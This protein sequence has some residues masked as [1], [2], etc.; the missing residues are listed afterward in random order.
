MNILPVRSLPA[1]G[2]LVLAVACGGA[3][4]DAPFEVRQRFEAAGLSPVG[5]R[6]SIQPEHQRAQQRYVRAA[7]ATLKNLGEWLGPFPQPSLAIVDPPWHGSPTITADAAV[8]LART[9]W[10]STTTSMAPELATARGV[11]RRV[12]STLVDTRALPSWFV[13]GFAEYASRRIVAALFEQEN[14]PPGYALV[15]ERY[16]DRFVP[17]PVRIRRLADSATG[18]PARVS[19]A[20]LLFGTLERWLSRPVFDQIVAEFVRA[21]RGGHPTVADFSR[22]A[23]DV[24]GQDLSWLFDEALGSLRVFDYG[25]GHLES[26]R[27]ADRAFD[28]TVTVRRFGD[29]QFTGASATPVG[30]F[31]SGRG[32]VLRVIFEDGQQRTDYWDGRSLEKT[33]RYRSPARAVSAAIDPDHLLLLDLKH[34]NNSITLAPQAGV[35]ASRWA[36]RWL[37]WLMH[38]LLN[39]AALV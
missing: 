20:F 38:A 26:A 39:A 18:V 6:F 33:F 11:S 28:T 13:D 10:W 12:L 4:P 34:T 25:V 27:T 30:P 16:F 37:P 15:E 24:S 36:I 3:R 21:S 9:P 2:V 17:L 22:T 1:F 5:I 23:S 7:M 14:L 35:V 31:E 32:L 19:R 8:V 29:A